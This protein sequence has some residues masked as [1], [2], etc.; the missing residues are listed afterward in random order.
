MDLFDKIDSLEKI[1]VSLFKHFFVCGDPSE[2]RLKVDYYLDRKSGH[3]LARVLFGRMAQGP[4]NHAHGGAI[5]AVLDEVMGF[6]AMMN[7]LPVMTA[8]ITI[9]Y[10]DPVRLGNDIAV[11][12][13]IDRVEEKK[14]FI[15]AEMLERDGRVLTSAEG[16]LIVQSLERI[17]ELGTIN[18][19]ILE[20]ILAMAKARSYT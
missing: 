1:D 17:R 15:K 16:L 12:G 11:K 5:A 4:P 3:L 7:G 10:F 2:E 9:E 20:K 14:V 18:P 19:E 6:T 13:W 8:K